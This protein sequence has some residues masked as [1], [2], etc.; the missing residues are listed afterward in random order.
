MAQVV[1]VG[2]AVLDHVFIV[3]EIPSIP[4]KWHATSYHPAGGGNAATAAVAI[5]RGGGEAV[6]WGRLGDDENGSW[7]LRELEEYGVSVDDVLR[8]EG[9]SSG[10]SSVLVDQEGERL[11]VNYSDPQL[12][13]D[14]DWLPLENLSEADAVLVDLR[15]HEGAKK[16][17]DDAR[18]Q[19]IPAVL[20]VDITPE[21]LEAEVIELSSHALFSEPALKQFSNGSTILA[22]LQQAAELNQGWVGVTCGAEGTSWLEDGQLRHQPAFPVKS[23]DTLGAGDVF[24]GLFALG[25][26]E[27]L[28]EERSLVRASA[29]AAISCSRTGGRDAIPLEH[30]IEAFLKERS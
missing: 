29:A 14:A 20:D 10:V 9:V 4:T 7:I 17:L 11:I 30:E 5:A 16:T 27:G 8:L 3:P 13:T 2:L 15:W 6:Y 19:D 28:S 18:K 23:V 26:A 25:L 24:H 22:G 21:G 12:I 1:C